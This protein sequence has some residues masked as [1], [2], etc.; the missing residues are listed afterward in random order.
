MSLV[1][2]R[3]SMGDACD[4]RVVDR[5][6]RGLAALRNPS[7]SNSR[8]VKRIHPRRSVMTGDRLLIG[9]LMT[10]AS[11]LT[12]LLMVLA[13]SI[14]GPARRESHAPPRSRTL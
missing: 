13:V 6:A 11:A 2:E 10:F 5:V 8:A 4:E 3:K 7:R 12:F 14:E 1:I 9:G